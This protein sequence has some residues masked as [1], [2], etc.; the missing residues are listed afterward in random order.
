[1]NAFKNMEALVLVAVALTVSATA[2]IRTPAA[3][4]EP[5]LAK[6]AQVIQ[7][8]VSAKRMTPAEKSKLPG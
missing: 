7:V 5:T 3:P 6:E 4:A 1:M 8:V 2:L